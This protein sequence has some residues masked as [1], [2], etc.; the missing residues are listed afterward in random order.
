[1][2]NRRKPTA[3][4]VMQG[5]NQPSRSNPAEPEF[6]PTDGLEPPE[7]L[8]DGEAVAAW[9]EWAGLLESQRVLTEAD[10]RALGMMCNM[11]SAAVQK[12]NAGA[13]PSAAELTQLRMMYNEF[14]LTPASR[15]KVS[16]LGKGKSKNAFGKLG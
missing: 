12:W 1:M 10:R 13:A 3:L 9:R 11:E 15:P 4:K 14:G 16:S 7:W 5:T 8:R 2:A 6:E